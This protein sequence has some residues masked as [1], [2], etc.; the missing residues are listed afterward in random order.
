MKFLPSPY[1][2]FIICKATGF[3][4]L[5]SQ[6]NVY[7]PID[8]FLILTFVTLTILRLRI[9]KTELTLLLDFALIVFIVNWWELAIYALLLTLFEAIYRR[10]YIALLT[11]VYITLLP[12]VSL[13][14]PILTLLSSLFLGNWERE[15]EF[16]QEQ[17]FQLRQN[18]HELEDL[19]QEI[20]VATSVT[21]RS[22]TLAERARISRDIHDNAGHDII[23]A[24]IAF[25]SLRGLLESESDDVLEMYDVTLNRL[26]SGVDKIRDILHNQIPTQVA[27]VEQLQKICADFTTCSINFYHYGNAEQV[28]TYLW[29]VF[30]TCLKES[31]TNVARHANASFVKVELDIS[32]HITR[33]SVENDG[34]PT[35]SGAPVGRGISNLRYRINAVGGNLS[36]NQDKDLFRVI[37]VVPITDQENRGGSLS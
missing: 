29:H 15:K 22:A 9:P 25:Q 16:Q 4:L 32:A 30:A 23:A 36:T 6:T 19:N 26:S 13:T 12:D 17:R 33:L 11:L 7:N 5:L 34:A 18:I 27:S 1:H 10:K 21:E 20:V 35:T 8:F 2:W 24:N 31:L 37:C 14:L 28:P 3:G